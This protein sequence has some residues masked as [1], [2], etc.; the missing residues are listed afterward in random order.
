M[1]AM[2][3]IILLTLIFLFPVHSAVAQNFTW[4]KNMGGAGN[5]TSTSMK[6]DTAGN[7]Y[8][9]GW[10]A[11]TVDFDPGPGVSNL[12][13]TGGDDVFIVKLSAAGNFLWARRVGGSS[14]EM[15]FSIAIDRLGN[16]YITGDFQ[17]SVDFDPG[18]GSFILTPPGG[19]SGAFLLKLDTAGNFVWAQHIVGVGYD[20]AIDSANSVYWTGHFY[21]TT[22]FNAD[23]AAVFNLTSSGISDIFISKITGAGNF[24]WA[25]RFGSTG[26][27]YSLSINLD[28]NNNVYTTGFFSGTCDFDPGSGVINLAASGA[29]DV[30]ISKL[31]SFG[32]FVWAKRIGGTA[33]DRG[34]TVEVDANGNLYVTGRFSGP[35]DLDPGPGTATFNSGPIFLVKLDPSGNY[36]WAKSFGGAYFDGGDYMSLDDYNNVYLT[37]YFQGTVA[38]DS[39]NASSTKTSNGG[40]DCYVVRFDSSGNYNWVISFGGPNNA[41]Q[42]D[43]GRSVAVGSDYK[44]YTTGTFLATV[45]FDPGTSVFN[46]TS[47]GTADIF[48][49]KIDQCGVA[50]S[51]VIAIPIVNAGSNQSICAG[52]S[53][54]LSAAGANT[55]NWSPATGLSCTNCSNPVASPPV[56]TF[57]VVSGSG[58]NGCANSD[59]INVMVN[60]IPSTQIV[61]S[62]ISCTGNQLGSISVNTTGGAPPYSYLWI[63]LS[64]TTASVN[65]LNAG[66]YVVTTSDANSCSKTDTASIVQQTTTTPSTPLVSI[67]AVTVDSLTGKNLVI[68]EKPGSKATMFKVYRE[69]TTTNVYNTIGAQPT[70]QFST[71]IDTGSIPLQQSY[72]YKISEVDS[73]GNEWPLSNHHK[74]IHLSSSIGTN[75]EVNLIWNLYE[76]ANYTTHYIMRNVNGTGFTSLAQVAGSSTSYSDLNPPAGP[77]Q[78]RIDIDLPTTCNP[79]AKITSYNRIS[80]NAVNLSSLGLGL[81]S[82]NSDVQIVPNPAENSI[83]VRGQKPARIKV[84]DYVGRTVASAADVDQVSLVHL[85]SGLY[86]IMLFDRAGRLYHQQKVEKR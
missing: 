64:A 55:Y 79:T 85:A 30:F 36:A 81:I 76:G 41:N 10:F 67:C 8:I 72:S 25:K 65:N 38:F 46:L 42:G 50:G 22:D 52:S 29:S 15:S 3:H 58:V 19:Y 33:G 35:A 2:R 62:D 57:Y 24:V 83:H 13:S 63:G 18:A 45:D 49:Q 70:S 53:A 73:C 54:Q 47:N 20:I 77:K 32:N 68:W 7:L 1:L 11:G 61:K 23:T 51:P 27:E 26:S 66:T 34:N 39:S 69:T 78:Y 82:S 80:S 71:L 43:V 17:G 48:V 37:G 9:T 5:E 4:A 12:S 75:G 86:Q 16:S 6:I 84:I 56:S 31:D 59:T 28:K 14:Y 40:Y 44:V 74:T 21:G 60:S